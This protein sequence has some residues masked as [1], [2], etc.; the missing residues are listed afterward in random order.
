MEVPC[1]SGLVMAVRKAIEASGK[2]IPFNSVV[3]GV[4]G[5]LQT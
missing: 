4:R 2:D 3:V 1:C 5:E